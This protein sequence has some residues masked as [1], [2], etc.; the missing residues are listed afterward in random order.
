M[1]S[2]IK[3]CI[4]AAARPAR[5]WLHI[6]VPGRVARYMERSCSRAECSPSLAIILLVAVLAILIVRFHDAVIYTAEMTGVVLG[7]GILLVASVLSLRTIVRVKRS[8][9]APAEIVDATPA[10]AV[11]PAVAPEPEPV[12]PVDAIKADADLLAKPGTLVLPPS[13]ATEENSPKE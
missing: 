7:T 3:R 1:K 9:P 12:S 4:A 5:P 13:W 6:T 10:E 8:R 11:A 2:F